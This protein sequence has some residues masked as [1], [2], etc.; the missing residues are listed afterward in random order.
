MWARMLPRS[1]ANA[2]VRSMEARL[3]AT[4]VRFRYTKPVEDLSRSAREAWREG[5]DVLLWGHFHTLWQLRRAGHVA[6]VVPAW[7]EFRCAVVVDE[8]GWSWAGE[9]LTPLTAPPTMTSGVQSD[10]R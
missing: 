3:A 5:V 6:L 7:L 4:N 1:L 10:Q 8:E 2:I 9:G